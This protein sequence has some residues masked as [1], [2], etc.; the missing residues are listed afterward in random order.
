MPVD[1]SGERAVLGRG[2]SAEAIPE[3]LGVKDWE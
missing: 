2:D 1:H 3:G